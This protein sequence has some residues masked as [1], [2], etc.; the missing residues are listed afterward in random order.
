M[1][2]EWGFASNALNSLLRFKDHCISEAHD[3]LS[4]L[5]FPDSKNIKRVLSHIK[6]RTYI[7]RS[8]IFFTPIRRFC[9][10]PQSDTMAPEPVVFLN[11]PVTDLKASEAFYEVLGLKKNTTWCSEDTSCMVLSKHIALMIMEPPRF[12]SCLCPHSILPSPSPSPFRRS[13]AHVFPPL[14]FGLD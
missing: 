3:Q 5:F 1:A 11:L 10:S 4:P 7:C 12:K 9:P 13:R 2:M 14:R 6:Q 8:S